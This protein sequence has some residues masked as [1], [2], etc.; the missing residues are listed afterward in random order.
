MSYLNPH[1]PVAQKV[2]D[3]LVFR[4]FQGEGVNFF[5]SLAPP[6]LKLLMRIFWEI[7]IK[8][9]P[10]FIFQWVLYEDHVLSQMFL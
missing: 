7:P 2:A 3:E 5:K 10:A 4:R 8:A 9:L 6:P 1:T